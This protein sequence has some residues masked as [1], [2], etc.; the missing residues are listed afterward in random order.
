MKLALIFDKLFDDIERQK[1]LSEIDNLKTRYNDPLINQYITLRALK[2]SKGVIEV[3][4]NQSGVVCLFD[5]YN[6]KTDITM[7]L[8]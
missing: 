3:F 7:T 5:I 6:I 1:L 4:I 8:E 2:D